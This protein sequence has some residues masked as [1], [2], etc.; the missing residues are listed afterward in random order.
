MGCSA[1]HARSIP[2]STR[3]NNAQPAASTNS[4]PTTSAKSA[5]G[6]VTPA[7]QKLPVTN[8]K[9]TSN[10]SKKGAS[11]QKRVSLELVKSASNALTTAKLAML[12]SVSNVT[13]TRCLSRIHA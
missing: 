10:L 9:K 5:H 4:F 7:P 3:R 13:M 1:L 8:A 12:A 11:V 2:S 6:A